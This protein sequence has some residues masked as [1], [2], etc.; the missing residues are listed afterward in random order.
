[1]E[2]EIKESCKKHDHVKQLMGREYDLIL[3]LGTLVS[4]VKLQYRYNGSLLFFFFTP[5][6]LVV[7]QMIY[8]VYYVLTT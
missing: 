1:M 4:S 5:P 8:D 7:V 6:T 2:R 3:K